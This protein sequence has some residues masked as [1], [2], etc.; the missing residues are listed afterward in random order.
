MGMNMGQLGLR[1]TIARLRG[2]QVEKARVRARLQAKLAA[3][4]AKIA[5]VDHETEAIVEDIKSLEA[6][7]A[8]VYSDTASDIGSRQT[9]PKTHV[10]D[11]G[12]LTRSIL[13]LFRNANG[14]PLSASKVTTQ[15]KA[16]L[17]LSFQ[18]PRAA[19]GFRRQVGRTLQNM[20]HAGY[21]QGL[22]D[23]T[24]QKE[25]IWRLKDLPE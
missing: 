13:Q 5:A 15:L 11:W 7:L 25:G 3:L 22:H 23:P 4:Q 24:A 2:A 18:E 1:H 10:T 12:N 17:D 20:R 8:A 16:A 21:L 9:F 6:A 14:G 19:S